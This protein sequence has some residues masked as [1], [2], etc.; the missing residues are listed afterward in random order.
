MTNTLSEASAHGLVDMDRLKPGLFSPGETDIATYGQYRLTEPQL[1]A[2]PSDVPGDHIAYNPSGIWTIP[3]GRDQSV[4]VMY[5][6]V[7]PDRSYAGASHLGKAVARPYV[8][9]P[10]N[11]LVPLRPFGE[12]G[13][14]DIPGEDPS[15]T[16]INRR[17]PIS[18]KLQ[19]VWLVGVVNA[20]P[21]PV[22]ANQVHSLVTEFR[23]GESLDKLELVAVGPPWMKDIRAALASPNETELDV[24]GRPQ[25]EEYSGN[26]T[27]TRVPSIEKLT[28]DVIADAPYI[29]EDIFPVGSGIWGGVNDAIQIAPNK[30][31]LATHRAWRTGMDGTGRHYEAVLH[32]HDTEAMTIIELGVIATADMF[33]DGKVKDDASVD[34]HDV[35]F[36]G[37]AYNG[38]LR[39]LTLGVRD[40]S[41]GIGGIRRILCSTRS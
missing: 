34:L 23:V 21:D 6:R 29:H 26:I 20:Q 13:S 37:G 5:V 3:T 28:P 11:P 16:R 19:S 17:L 36:T 12:G 38:K 30:Y 32:G 18:G 10:R 31:V 9:N 22:I 7:E 4:D 2:K 40:G 25:T 24:W 15:F 27:Y 8:V 33:P 1:F 14:L 41:I 35:A 39:Y